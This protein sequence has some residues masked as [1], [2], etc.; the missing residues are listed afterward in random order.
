M[1][2]LK[3]LIGI[4]LIPLCFMAMFIVFNKAFAA[5]ETENSKSELLFEAAMDYESVPLIKNCKP[6]NASRTLYHECR[7]SRAVYEKAKQSALAKKQPLMIL[8]LIHI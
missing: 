6:K 4:M 3:T 5:P 1:I 7:D 8:S 2:K